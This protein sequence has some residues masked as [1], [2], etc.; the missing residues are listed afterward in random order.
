MR[1]SEA[2]VGTGSTFC[3]K[4]VGASPSHC[5]IDIS[6]YNVTAAEHRIVVPRERLSHCNPGQDAWQFLSRIGRV[7]SHQCRICSIRFARG[8]LVQRRT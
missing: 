2:I 5:C 3:I 8:G 7:I 6:A 4:V 1:L